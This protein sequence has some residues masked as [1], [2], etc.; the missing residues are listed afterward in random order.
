MM[1]L[2]SLKVTKT[3]SRGGSFGAGWPAA[4]G[5]DIG[6]ICDFGDPGGMES[7]LF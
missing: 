6:V 5:L 2:I 1:T 4:A 3:V 7:V